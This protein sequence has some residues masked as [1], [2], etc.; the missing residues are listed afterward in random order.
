MYFFFNIKDNQFAMTTTTIK[1]Y[2]EKDLKTDILLKTN[3]KNVFEGP[4]L[5]KIVLNVGVKEAN[6]NLN[7]ILIPMLVSKLLT[8]QQPTFT[9]AHKSIANFKLREGKIIGCKVTL[10]NK[11]K[12]NFLEKLV[13]IVIPQL[14]EHSKLRYKNRRPSNDINL[15]IEDCNFFFELENQYDTITEIIG[16]NININSKEKKQNKDNLL[17][18][19]LKFKFQ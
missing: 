2:F 13:H 3:Y 16:I 10:R 5:N 17:Y 8:Q 18:S 9:K 7:K 6:V 1:S 15:G 19:G 12:N 14:A 4:T 11:N